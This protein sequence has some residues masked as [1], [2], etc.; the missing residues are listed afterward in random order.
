MRRSIASGDS[1]HLFSLTL[2]P[3]RGRHSMNVFVYTL[4]TIKCIYIM[5][6]SLKTML[7]KFIV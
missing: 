5:Y 3:E 1:W 7:L 4:Y 2:S 6:L